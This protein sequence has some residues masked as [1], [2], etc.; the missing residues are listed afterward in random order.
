MRSTAA[1]IGGTHPAPGALP[2][3][4]SRTLRTSGDPFL[5][6]HVQLQRI[7]VLLGSDWFR[8]KQRAR[9]RGHR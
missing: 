1:H 6:G 8:V 3:N 2:K 7:I 9:E 5:P 4:T